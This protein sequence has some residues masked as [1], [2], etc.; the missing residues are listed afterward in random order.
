T[1]TRVSALRYRFEGKITPGKQNTG[2][3]IF[4]YVGSGSGAPVKKATARSLSDGRYAWTLTLPR[5]AI[6]AYWATGADM[7]N[8]AGKSAVK[9]FTSS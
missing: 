7:T 6:R 1:T 4:L 2:R 5:G 3:A 8:L 9:S